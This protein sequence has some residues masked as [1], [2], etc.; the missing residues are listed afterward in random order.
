MPSLFAITVASNSLTLNAQRKGEAAFAMFN[1]S[2]RTVRGRAVLVPQ[3]GAAPD[4]FSIVGEAERDFAPSGAAQYTVQ[5]EIPP[6]APPG[7]YSFRLDMVNVANPDEDYT[8]GQGVSFGVPESSV[9]FRI[10]WWVYAVAGAVGVLVVVVVVFLV[11]RDGGIAVP[12]VA[13][14]SAEEAVRRLNEAGLQ[15]SEVTELEAS[16]TIEEGKVIR[17]EPPGGKVAGDMLMTLVLSAGPEEVPTI[18]P[19]DTIVPP[20]TV[21]AELSPPVLE[22]PESRNGFIS[23]NAPTLTGQ[24]EGGT[25]VKVLKGGE[26]VA[27]GPVTDGRFSI[28]LPELSE[29]AHEFT[30][31]VSDGTGNT[32]DPSETITVTV[33]MTPPVWGEPSVIRGDLEAWNKID[34]VVRFPCE[35]SLSGPE[36]GKEESQVSTQGEGSDLSLEAPAE[37]CLDR[38]GNQTVRPLSVDGIRVDMTP[39]AYGAPT[40]APGSEPN[41][42]GWNNTDV[43]VRFP[44]EDSLSGPAAGVVEASSRGEGIDLVVVAPGEQCIDQAGNAAAAS[45]VLEGIKVDKTPPTLTFNAPPSGEWYRVDVTIPFTASDNFGVAFTDPPTGELVLAQE[46]TAIKAQV[47]VTDLAGNSATF[48]TPEFKIDKTPPTLA[49][50]AVSALSL[51]SFYSASFSRSDGPSGIS[52]VECRLSTDNA[53]VPNCSSPWSSG[54]FYPGPDSPV[55]VVRVTDLAGNVSSACAPNDCPILFPTP[56]IVVPFPG[57][58]EFID[59]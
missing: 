8:Q 18:P 3:G 58:G 44:C 49:V 55:V 39:P 32:S 35:D 5:I 19:P 13:E 34:V 42:N 57:R 12:D 29:G 53:W 4:W 24:A 2:G 11:T 25:E 20:P 54:V 31:V 1:S 52:S 28:R 27:S 14:L 36:A 47:T 48:E 33:D 10:P 15:V 50:S 22:L 51:P 38:A 41:E 23:N 40:R 59:P 16:G 45:R 7:E 56:T 37:E 30:A 46:G 26:E 43:T 9:P 17:T 21:P 6:G